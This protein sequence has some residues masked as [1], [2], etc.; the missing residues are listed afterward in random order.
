[1]AK[2]SKGAKNPCGLLHRTM[3]IKPGSL[4]YE[5]R[6]WRKGNDRTTSIVDGVYLETAEGSSW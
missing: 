6:K 5:A 3:D 1:M 2:F 4:S